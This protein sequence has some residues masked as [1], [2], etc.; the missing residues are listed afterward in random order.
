MQQGFSP[1]ASGVVFR[2]SEARAVLGSLSITKKPS[3]SDSSIICPQPPHQARARGG[4]QRQGEKEKTDAPSCRSRVAPPLGSLLISTPLA[5]PVQHR[6]PAPKALDDSLLAR[7]MSGK[8]GCQGR[9]WRRNQ[10][11]KNMLFLPRFFFTCAAGTVSSRAT[12]LPE[13]KKEEKKQMDDRQERACSNSKR[14]I[15]RGRKALLGASRRM[16]NRLPQSSAGF[17]MDHL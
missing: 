11:T 10:F 2:S 4:E 9:R 17:R 14:S 7:S 3:D 6:Q 15:A 12:F 8:G 1:S 5:L 16:Q 13:G